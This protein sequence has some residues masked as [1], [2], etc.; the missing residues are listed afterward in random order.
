VGSDGRGQHADELTAVGRIQAALARLR[1]VASMAEML[2]RIPV[3][4]ASCGFERV[5][6]S[7]PRNDRWWP[8]AYHWGADPAGAA[9]IM[10]VGRTHARLLDHELR[11]AEMLRRRRPLLVLDA[12]R[13]P[14]VHPELQAVTRTTSYV[15]AP[16]MPEGYVVAFLHADFGPSGRTCTP[17]DRDVL[18]L[19][20]EG[21]GYAYERTALLERLRELPSEVERLGTELLRV[22]DHLRGEEVL[23][24]RHPTVVAGT[25]PS[26][27]LRHLSSR[28]LEVLRL[29]AGGLRNAEIAERLTLSEPTVKSHVRRILRKMRASN[30]AH[31]VDRYWRTTRGRPA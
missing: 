31:A 7:R 25:P 2:E 4:A 1:T 15:A 22:A 27:E 10:E 13:D 23:A 16:I 30:R 14:L 20:A 9:R 6:M 12:D 11:D 28:E 29:M 8:E 5:M 3:E 18:W 19:F 17:F 24:E 21:A 26:E